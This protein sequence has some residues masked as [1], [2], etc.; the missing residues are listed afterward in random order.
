MR[1]VRLTAAL[2]VAAVGFAACDANPQGI[3]AGLSDRGA[4]VVEVV[5]C[6]EEDVRSVGVRSG[7]TVIWQVSNG[8]D[9]NLASFMVGETPEGFTEHVALA[10]GPDDDFEVFVVRERSS[11]EQYE[12]TARFDV[13]ELHAQELLIDGDYFG[14]EEFGERSRGKLCDGGGL[15]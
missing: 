4:I 14:F 3:G 9:S 1:T 10:T 5:R 11:G 12:T 6:H 15:F 7:G 8:G 2:I 13:D